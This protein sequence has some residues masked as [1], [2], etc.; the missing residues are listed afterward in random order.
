[1]GNVETSVAPDPNID[2]NFE[3]KLAEARRLH[4]PNYDESKEGGGVADK[5]EWLKRFSTAKNTDYWINS[6]TGQTVYEDPTD[7]ANKPQI[8]LH[9]ELKEKLVDTLANHA[10]MDIAHKEA[11]KE[12][13]THLLFDLVPH[14]DEDKSHDLIIK[15]FRTR[16]ICP[17]QQDSDGNTLLI[18]AAEYNSYDM[19]FH[20]VH[21]LKADVNICNIHGCTA[22]FYSCSVPYSIE[23][24]ELLLANGIHHELVEY[25][26]GATALHYAAGI[27]DIRLVAVLLKYECNTAAPDHQG[28]YPED[29]ARDAGLDG[30]VTILQKGRKRPKPKL[31]EATDVLKF[32]TQKDVWNFEYDWEEYQDEEGHI[33]YYKK[34]TNETT[35]TRPDVPKEYIHN[36]IHEDHDPADKPISPETD[37][38]GT[39]TKARMRMAAPGT[40]GERKTLPSDGF[41][42]NDWEVCY[43]DAT[44]CSFY[45]NKVTGESKWET[46][47]ALQAMTSDM[48]QNEHKAKIAEETGSKLEETMLD[49]AAAASSKKEAEAVRLAVNAAQATFDKDRSDLEERIATLLHENEL[50]NHKVGQIPE[51]EKHL[52]D[53]K[54]KIEDLNKVASESAHKVA[55]LLS[56]KEKD[57]NKAN[58]DIVEHL[59]ETHQHAMDALQ[60]NLSQEMSQM[61]MKFEENEKTKELDFERKMKNLKEEMKNSLEKAKRDEEDHL[62]AA[63]KDA[64][65]QIDL[66]KHSL[67][68]KEKE[69]S[70]AQ[71]DKELAEK[72]KQSAVDEAIQK[73]H[74]KSLG[75]LMG[76]KL[77]AKIGHKHDEKEKQKLMQNYLKESNLRRKVYNELED[78]K[79]AIRVFCRVRPESK[80]EKERGAK[81]C[82]TLEKMDDQNNGICTDLKIEVKKKLQAFTFDRIFGPTSSQEEVFADTKRLIQSAVDG[83]NVCIFAY[84]QTGAGKSFTMIGAEGEEAPPELKGLTPRAVDEIYNLKEHAEGKYTVDISL[85]MFELYQDQLQDLLRPENEEAR[86][87]PIK[88]DKRNNVDI[89][90]GVKIDIE[91]AEDLMEKWKYSMS[92]RHV[93]ATKM[94]A[95][96]SRSHLVQIIY[97]TT[98]RTDGKRTVGKLTLVD[99]AGSERADRTGATG[100]GAKEA[101]A[102]NKSLSALGNVINALTTNQKHIPYRNSNLTMLMRDSIGGN[103]KTLMFVNISPADDNASE[104]FSSLNFAQRCKKVTNTAKLGVSSKELEALKREVAELKAKQMK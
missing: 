55:S 49:A 93:R 62:K 19:A 52:K 21:T 3:K 90:G 4:D 75:D 71:N 81:M 60:Q 34:S 65:I 72:E 83:F 59:K 58:E 53:A 10:A 66:L 87:L 41:S 25:D 35:W 92:R 97:L 101:L 39:A 46:P 89:I 61:R 64:A 100:E 36:M 102:I 54:T 76:Q 77:I 6:Y 27:N 94:N 104:T 15:V 1:M 14:L 80:S 32:V 13:A 37:H 16:E 70:K 78:L 12:A 73:C 69:L 88:I 24:T 42:V 38:G 51:L 48:H 103:S 63:K 67:E 74:A 57:D 50:L 95:V 82:V 86:A 40:M 98:V 45:Y 91:S 85:S 56:A 22:L 68:I 28:F 47:I 84:G 29:Y 30:I 99:L 5:G 79:G 18:Y 9:P 17:N 33:Y 96:S 31:K 43:D 2:I 23:I 20:L 8:E 26:H 44:N 11:E 7:G